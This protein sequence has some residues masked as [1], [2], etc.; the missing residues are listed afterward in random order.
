MGHSQLDGCD[1]TS[2][3]ESVESL[4]GVAVAAQVLFRAAT[5]VRTLALQGPSQADGVPIVLGDDV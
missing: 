4:N 2:V 1:T 5:S 3:H